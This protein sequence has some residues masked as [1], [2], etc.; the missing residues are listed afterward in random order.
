[1][2][3][4]SDPTPRPNGN[5]F[6]LSG[7]GAKLQV[8]GRDVTLFVLLIAGFG[9]LGWVTYSGFERML[10]GQADRM[11]EHHAIVSAQ[12]NTACTISLPQEARLDA[13]RDPGGA[14]HYAR[15]IYQPRSAR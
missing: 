9:S 7:W 11:A 8:N 12:D 3:G 15:L 5:G 1:M 2:T 14:C 6:T 4:P 10:N 13:I